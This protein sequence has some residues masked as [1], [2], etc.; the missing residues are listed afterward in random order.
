MNNL[1]T[2]IIGVVIFLKLTGNNLE[3]NNL[4]TFSSNLRNIFGSS[5]KKCQKY[6]NDLSGSWEDGYYLLK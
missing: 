2:F 4:E 1:I 5:L 3:N 6:D